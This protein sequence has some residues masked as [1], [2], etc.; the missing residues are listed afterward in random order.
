MA[1]SMPGGTLKSCDIDGAKTH[2]F[3]QLL[4][5]RAVVLQ[6]T[7][8]SKESDMFETPETKEPGIKPGSCSINYTTT[9]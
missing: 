2:A 4:P 1:V 9:G 7:Q 5:A 6:P 3:D 8:V